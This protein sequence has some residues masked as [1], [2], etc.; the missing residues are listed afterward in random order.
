METTRKLAL[1]K[2]ETQ[3]ATGNPCVNGHIAPRRAKT[4]ECIKCR[5]IHLIKWRK[6]NPEKVKKHNDTQHERFAERLAE[7]A[8]YYYHLDV[9]KS[10][11]ALRDYQK[12]NLHIFAKAKAKRKA[13]QLQRTPAWLT[14]DDY[15]M[16]EQAYEV[17]AQRTKLFG[18]PW[19]V[20]HIIPLQGKL[21]S[22]LHTP[23]NL[24]VIPGVENIRKGNR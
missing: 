3:Y 21:V 9:D 10:R 18:F 15:W 23:F 8:R 2:G 7:R 24:Q 12:N 13:A 20:D 19:H 11:A 17:A 14:T 5:A 4:G 1:I 6:S 16:I 22:G